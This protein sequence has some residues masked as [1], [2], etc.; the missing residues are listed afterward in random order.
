MNI[1]RKLHCMRSLIPF[2]VHASARTDT[3]MWPA[4]R[5]RAGFQARDIIEKMAS[6]CGEES[7]APSVICG[8]ILGNFRNNFRKDANVLLVKG[9]SHTG[10]KETDNFS[11]F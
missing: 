4:R 7:G 3:Q 2:Y 8:T 9:T 1:I 5:F 10:R 11:Q 6:N